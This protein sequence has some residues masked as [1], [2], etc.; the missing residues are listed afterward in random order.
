MALRGK[1]LY[2]AIQI[3]RKFN[4]HDSTGKL[5]SARSISL[6]KEYQ[7]NF[8]ASR[9]PRKGADTSMGLYNP[10]TSIKSNAYGRSS[11]ISI[12]SRKPSSQL[13]E[14]SF[15]LKILEAKV[16][17]DPEINEGYPIRLKTIEQ[18]FIELNYK[19]SGR[20]LNDLYLN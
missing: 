4:Q 6:G 15:F 14:L 19:L 7:T 12:V 10:Q 11:S 16:R 2:A 8:V 5:E 18:L 3:N 9:N 17:F 13:K 1:S 20:Q